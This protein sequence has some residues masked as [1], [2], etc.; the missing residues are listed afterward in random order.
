MFFSRL[1]TVTKYWRRVSWPEGGDEDGV[2]R[3]VDQHNGSGQKRRRWEPCVKQE[4]NSRTVRNHHQRASLRAG[5]REMNDRC[6]PQ[7]WKRAA[8]HCARLNSAVDRADDDEV[9]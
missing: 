7:W 5:Q 1:Q 6:V 3:V 4:E 8:I 2:G 9:T